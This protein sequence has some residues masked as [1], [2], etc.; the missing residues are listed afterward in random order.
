MAA[1][2]IVGIAGMFCILI[3]FVLDEFEW[4][5]TRDTKGYNLFNIFGSGALLYY[6]YTLQAWPF[7]ILNLVWLAV[8]VIKLMRI[9]K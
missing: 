2:L 1:A 6:G 5:L 7:V 4:Y 8:A 9:I 3:A